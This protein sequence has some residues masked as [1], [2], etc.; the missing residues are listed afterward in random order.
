MLGATRYDGVADWYDDVFLGAE[1][2]RSAASEALARALG[3]G[4]GRCLD[5]GCG[6]G[7]FLARLAELGW[8]PVGLDESAAMLERARRRGPGIEL[9]QADATAI[10]FPDGSFDAAVSMWTHTDIDDFPACVEE[11][12]RVLTPGAPFAYVGA[13]PCFVGPHSRFAGAQGVPAL[14]PGYRRTGRY[15]DGPGVTPEGLRARVGASHLTLS[16]LVQSFLAAGFRLEL[17]EE[18]PTPPD[19]PYMLALRWRR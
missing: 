18:V 16:A 7:V 13:H 5:V 8:E 6:T 19:Y 9:V 3:R 10:P 1:P 14:H 17:F 15:S 4:S 11:I 12:A 2:E